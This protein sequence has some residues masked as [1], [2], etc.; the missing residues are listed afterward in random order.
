MDRS[1]LS[2][3]PEEFD[4]EEE[5]CTNLGASSLTS[6]EEDMFGFRPFFPFLCEYEDEAVASDAVD[7]DAPDLPSTEETAAETE[8]AVFPCDFNELLQ[9]LPLLLLLFCRSGA[10]AE[11]REEDSLSL[12]E[13]SGLLFSQ[14]DAEVA[15]DLVGL[16]AGIVFTSF[17]F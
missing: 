15:M 4:E 8:S 6:E 10:A 3:P 7:G 12:E 16:N 14:P 11:A 13:V 5:S 17:L 9:P 1:L 2:S